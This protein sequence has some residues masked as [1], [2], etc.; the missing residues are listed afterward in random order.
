MDRSRGFIRPVPGA[1][2][3]CRG[4]RSLG[5]CG[6]RVCHPGPRLNTCDRSEPYGN[7]FR[8]RSFSDHLR[9]GATGIQHRRRHLELDSQRRCRLVDYQPD[10]GSGSRADSVE[11]RRLRPHPGNLPWYHYGERRRGLQLAP[12]RCGDNEC[13]CRRRYK[14]SFRQFRHANQPFHRAEQHR[15]H[16]L[17]PG[18]HRG[19]VTEDLP[20]TPGR[21]G[22]PAQWVRVHW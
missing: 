14:R 7:H 5:Y 2:E 1:C 19:R 22:H 3:R 15:G 8:L 18:R 16:R 12:D 9:P 10:N 20:R 11:H 17:G 6:R 4:R 21:G 13:V